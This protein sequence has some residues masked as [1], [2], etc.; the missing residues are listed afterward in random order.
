VFKFFFYIDDVASQGFLEGLQHSI[1][2]GGIQPS[3]PLAHFQS[4]LGDLYQHWEATCENSMV[5]AAMEFING[6]ALERRAEITQMNVCPS[7]KNRPKYL[8]AKSGMVPIFFHALHFRWQP[9][10]ISARHPG[11]SGRQRV[12]ISIISITLSPASRL[13]FWQSGPTICV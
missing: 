4:V 1:S 8:R 9:I 11:A 13:S 7:A 12:S 5:S 6:T 10:L 3:G 2:V